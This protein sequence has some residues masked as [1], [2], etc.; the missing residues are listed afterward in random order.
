MARE[1]WLGPILNDNR[2]RLVARCAELIASGRGHRF[3]YL[4]ATKPLMD[5]VVASLAA[6]AT[7]AVAAR[8]PNVFLLSGFSR[9]IL[10]SARFADT[11]APLPYYA[12]IE[13]SAFPAQM[14]LFGR[15]VA[16]LAADGQLPSF[17]KL[18]QTDGLVAS[19]AALVT[20]IQRAGKT[21]DDFALI[22]ERRETL[23]RESKPQPRDPDA[24]DASES[25]ALVAFDRDI[26]RVYAA[27]EQVLETHRLTDSSRDYLRSLAVLGGALNGQPVEVPMLD[28]VELLV[29]DGFFD[30]L[31]VHVEL[32]R[33]LQTRIPETIATLNFDPANPA[34]FEAFRDVRERCVEELGFTIRMSERMMP[35]AAGLARLRTALFNAKAGD[36]P[37]EPVGDAVT[38]IAATDR[39]REIRAVAK[40][41]RRL[42]IDG[43]APA[44]IAVVFRSRDPYEAVIREVFGDERIAVSIGERRALR[45]LPS[46][47]AALKVLDAAGAG[48]LKV[49]KLVALLKCDYF[50][51]ENPAGHA[52]SEGQAA[53]PFEAPDEADVSLPSDDVEN[54][55]A[56]VGENLS[57]DDW[58]QRARALIGDMDRTTSAARRMLEERMGV[59]GEA[60]PA[61]GGDEPARPMRRRSRR[62]VSPEILRRTAGI[63]TALGEV[64]SSIPGA[65]SPDSLAEALRAAL[66]RLSFRN[67]MLAATRAAVGDRVDL[68]RCVLDLRGLEGLEAALASVV[69]AAGI[70]G[71]SPQTT[72]AEFATDLD[73]ALG[74]VELNVRR[75]EPAGVQA[76]AASDVRGMSFPVV[77]VVGLVEGEYPV[78]ARTDWIY[79]QT[80][81]TNLHDAGLPLEDISPEESLAR[82]EHAFYQTVCRAT[83]RLILTRPVTDDEG[84][85]TIPSYFV[86]EVERALG[87]EL[88]PRIFGPGFDG[89]HLLEASTPAELARSVARAVEDAAARARRLDVSPDVVAAIDTFARTS[90]P[91]P[92]LT[93]SV[94][95]RI[96]IERRRETGAF[97]EYDGRISSR[98]LA[99]RVHAAFR[100][101]AFSATELGEFGNCGFRFFLKR[102]LALEP[103]VEAALDLQGLDR[104]TLL[105][106]ALQRFF[107]RHRDG[108]LLEASADELR[109]ELRAIADD[110]LDAFER[111]MPPLNPRL[112]RIEREVLLILLDRFLDDELAHQEQVAQAGLRPR[113][114]ELGFGVGSADGDPESI[115]DPFVLEAGDGTPIRIRGKIDRVD[116]AADGTVIAYDYKSGAGP[117]VKEMEAGRDFQLG[118]YLD[119]LERAVG[120][121]RQKIAGGGYYSLKA[122]PPRRNQ[123]L[124]LA[125]RQ[126]VT[127]LTRK[128]ASQLDRDRFDQVRDKIDDNIRSVV[129]RIR[130]ADFR[131]LPSEN[132]KTCTYCDYTQ[133]CRFDRHRVQLKNK[134]SKG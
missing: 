58:L 42:V 55:V 20:E 65:G 39:R 50:A 85:D 115:A 73:R 61:E 90:E 95:R 7:P 103:R 84:G 72:R 34:P 51:L 33:L 12:S 118:I 114:L 113:Y 31:P 10:R 59:E 5:V 36:A 21:A 98:A 14:P 106:A 130:A 129:A 66:D 131:L 76:F 100:E 93:A 92:I 44:D 127:G 123:G 78:R 82:E 96:A 48:R 3:I 2:E 77:F 101:H 132:E 99:A 40:E 23:A 89:E 63:L 47:R 134:L 97:D 32:L 116:R 56:F 13:S 43:F 86:M 120:I 9:E 17:G 53:L 94:D 128:T 4:A 46:V 111:S 80:E 125:D 15:I 54:A 37:T 88:A 57:L 112:W 75:G 107:E 38:M 28:G 19:V 67:R 6:R 119:A 52:G 1:L 35:V 110:V 60:G 108:R 64:V 104:G 117:S 121:D 41:I 22:V 70:A 87:C 124:Y 24:G 83:A 45:D 68:E 25:P 26:A 74:A 29:V 81:R 102:V 8:R 122:D 71:G 11:G 69:G 91:A 18:A 62:D 49:A 79:P 126:D 16:E 30:I 109:R 27:Y 105:H 133:V